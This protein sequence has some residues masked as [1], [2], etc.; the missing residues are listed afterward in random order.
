MGGKRAAAKRSFVI[1]KAE[2]ETQCNEFRI[3]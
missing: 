1:T 3:M 2:I